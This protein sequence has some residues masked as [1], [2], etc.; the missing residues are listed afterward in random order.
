MA[1]Q[2][3]AFEESEFIFARSGSNV[4]FPPLAFAGVSHYGDARVESDSRGTKFDYDLTTATQAAALPLLLGERD[5]LI[6]GEY[7]SWSEFRVRDGGD[8]KFNVASVGLPLGWLR[9]VNNDWQA[10]AFVFPLAHKADFDDAEWSWQYMGGVFGRYVQSER[11]WWAFGFYADIA[12]DD[13]F[14]IPYLGATW[15]FDD[16][17]TLSA[18][19]PWPAVLYAPSQDWLFRIGVS[20]SGASWSVSPQGTQ[21]DV[22]LN[23][24]AWDLGVSVERRLTGG[25]YASL[26]TGIGG[27][28][29]LRLDSGSLED[30]DFSVHSSPYIQLDI[31]F[32]PGVWAP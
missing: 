11:L 30:T 23:L 20:P 14:Y 16:H 10:A 15:A 27:F 12:P 31:K 13:N 22:A 5:A 24:D 3:R 32:R 7:V 4:P 28:R 26:E 1:R 21:D 29:G 2:T 8:G 6:I 25:I 18:I 9:Q 19:M 17:W